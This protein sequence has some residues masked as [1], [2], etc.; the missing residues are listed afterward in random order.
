MT[1][2]EI[3]NADKIIASSNLIQPSKKHMPIGSMY[4]ISGNI[5][6]QYTPNVSIYTS[7][8]DPM[9]C[10]FTNHRNWRKNSSVWGFSGIS[11][12]SHSKCPKKGSIQ[13]T[14]PSDRKVKFC[15]DVS[16]LVLPQKPLEFSS[17][18]SDWRKTNST[19]PL[20]HEQRSGLFLWRSTSFRIIRII[21]NHINI[22]HINIKHINITLIDYDH[23]SID[24]DSSPAL[25]IPNSCFN[26]CFFLSNIEIQSLMVSDTYNRLTRRILTLPKGTA[27]VYFCFTSPVPIIL[28]VILRPQL[29]TPQH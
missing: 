4:A 2:E 9:G 28:K 11:F 23:D 25:P 6:H 3:Q 20:Y 29:S 7:T 18:T 12:C 24:Y 15:R 10:W 17:W 26:F 8:M 5:Y 13:S 19:E 14:T 21:Q 27:E 16:W 1:T 22:K